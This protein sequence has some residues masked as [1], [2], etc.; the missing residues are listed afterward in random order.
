MVKNVIALRK[1][2]WT[3]ANEQIHTKGRGRREMIA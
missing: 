3:D 2:E 1:S